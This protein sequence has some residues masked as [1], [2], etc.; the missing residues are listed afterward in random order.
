MPRT[1]TAAALLIGNEILA[2][3]IREKNLFEL[4]KLLRSLGVALERVVVIADEEAIIADEVK[5]LSSSHDY[6]FTSGGVGPTH[7]DVTMAGVAKAFGVRVVRDPTLEQ[8]I[9]DYHDGEITDGHLNL[10]RVPKGAR[11]LTATGSRW[12][13]A[14]FRNVWILPGI[15]EVFQAKLAIVREHLKGHAPFVS[16]AVYT[17]L[18]E[19]I[20]KPMLDET[21][22]RHPKVD[23]GS[24]PRWNDPKYETKVT[25]DGKDEAAVER[26]F[27]EFQELLPDGEP[28][29]TE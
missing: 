18:D 26:A 3:K 14:V 1:E 7:D 19:A 17:K 11:M 13:A 25:F 24:Y 4:A 20:L 16:R 8:M 15:P 5:R 9:R 12:P 27:M 23:V 2:G 21:V 6:V 28:Q 22:A 10:A 29:W